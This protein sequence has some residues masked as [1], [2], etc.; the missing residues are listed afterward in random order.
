MRRSH[1]R[2]CAVCGH[3][4]CSWVGTTQDEKRVPVCD[5]CVAFWTAFGLLRRLGPSA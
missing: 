2:Q 5:G 1:K 4:G 3:V